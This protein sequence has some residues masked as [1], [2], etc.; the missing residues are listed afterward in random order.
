MGRL[1]HGIYGV[2]V[3]IGV[4]VGVGYRMVI[5]KEWDCTV[6]HSPYMTVTRHI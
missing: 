2:G 1:G 6:W 5:L 3:G 4:G